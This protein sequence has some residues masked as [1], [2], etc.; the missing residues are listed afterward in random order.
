MFL[1][2]Y[3]K[4]PCNDSCKVLNKYHGANLEKYLNEFTFTLKVVSG[5]KHRVTFEVDPSRCPNN[6]DGEIKVSK[7]VENYSFKE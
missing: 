6:N 3:K 7:P 2:F 5:L 4:N 1:D